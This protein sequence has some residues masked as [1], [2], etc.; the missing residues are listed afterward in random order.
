[1]SETNIFIC[2]FALF[3]AVLVAMTV[4][5]TPEK[6]VSNAPPLPRKVTIC[7]WDLDKQ[8][9]QGD[10]ACQQFIRDYVASRVGH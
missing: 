5:C 2:I 6:L 8:T 9:F 10:A 3:P 7:Q 4:A 1:M